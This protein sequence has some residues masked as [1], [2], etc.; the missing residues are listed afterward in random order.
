[1]SFAVVF[2][3]LGTD[4]TPKVLWSMMIRNLNRGDIRIS[5]SSK[6]SVF[7]PT[8]TARQQVQLRVNRSM[9]WLFYVVYY[10]FLMS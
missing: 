6:E 2:I 7:V 9:N 3:I 8:G 5:G 1:M 10:I 4:E